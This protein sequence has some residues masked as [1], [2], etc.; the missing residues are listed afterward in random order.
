MLVRPSYVLGGRAMQ[1]V[2]D[3]S[4]LDTYMREAVTVSPEHPVLVDRFLA[5]AIEVDVDAL[6]DGTQAVIA[7]IMEHIE[8][9]GIHSGD[10]ACSLPPYSL[11]RFLIEEI[12]RSTRALALE[13]GVVGLMNVQF[14]IADESVYVLEVNPRASRTVPFVSKAIGVPIAQLAAR[15]MAGKSLVELGFTSEV[16]P[17]HVS[18]KEAV[19]PFV[20]FPAVDTLLGPEMKSTGEVM[21]I[22]REFGRA[23]AKAQRGAGMDLPTRGTVL[24]SLRDEDK[25]SGAGALRV[26]QEEG[27][28][29][30]ATAGTA[31]Y[32]RERGLDVQPIHKVREGAPHTESLISSGEVSLVIA[33][34][35]MGDASAVR[36]SASMRRAAL[37]AGIPYFTTVAGAR[38]AASAIR[39]LRAGEVQPI[40]LQ[41]LH[42]V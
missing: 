30:V 21:G 11:P 27:F 18:V 6:C 15:V 32:M 2:H 7:G 34:T 39:A 37:E 26:L 41:D 20:K 5:N 9:A 3:S 35:R 28:A 33:T 14:A 23:Y 17:S 29:L 12:E 24:V 38:A 31:A 13:L 36:D 25:A 19:F 40:A 16:V 22:D 4:Q 10:S 8:E 42:T 1:I